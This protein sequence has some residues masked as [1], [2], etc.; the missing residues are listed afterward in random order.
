[1]GSL[2]ACSA[3]RTCLV[4]ISGDRSFPSRVRGSRHTFTN[5]QLCYLS[6]FANLQIP[7]FPAFLLL[8]V[9]RNSPALVRHFR[10]ASSLARPYSTVPDPLRQVS[11]CSWRPSANRT[12]LELNLPWNLKSKGPKLQWVCKQYFLT[13][14]ISYAICCLRP[15]SLFPHQTTPPPQHHVIRLPSLQVKSTR[16]SFPSFITKV[17]AAISHIHF[18]QPRIIL[19]CLLIS[20]LA[21]HSQHTSASST[22]QQSIIIHLHPSCSAI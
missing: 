16:A 7:F 11:T 2:P 15:F 21:Y 13:L 4:N 10:G 19:P 5:Q 17:L 14:L 1:M 3:L 20:S 18:P 6:F 12:Q 22:T 8:H 9:T